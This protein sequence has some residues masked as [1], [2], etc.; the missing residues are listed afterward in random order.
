MTSP[1]P[2]TE[3]FA[4]PNDL[5][6]TAHG[7]QAF[8][9]PSRRGHARLELPVHTAGRPATTQG[10]GSRAALAALALADAEPLVSALEQWLGEALDPVPAWA[11]QPQP[12]SKDS[13]QEACVSASVQGGQLAP[14]ASRLTLPVAW[15]QTAPASA[16]LSEALEWDSVPTRVILDHLRTACAA[17]ALRVGD[18]LLLPGS[19]RAAWAAQ[20]AAVGGAELP[21]AQ[22]PIDTSACL[23][24]G[25]TATTP[26][27]PRLPAPQAWGIEVLLPVHLPLAALLPQ[28]SPSGA[29]LTH[30]PLT[31]LDIG[32]FDA[33][34]ELLAIG[35]LLPIAQ[36][37]GLRVEEVT[38]RSEG[39]VPSEQAAPSLGP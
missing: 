25:D 26:A 24:L 4:G 19:Y 23:R 32:V 33:H 18:V 16:E 21:P 17:D 29:P 22:L 38:A 10:D 5:D 14:E 11:Q 12:A 6:A 3:A 20:A 13:D 9:V 2:L 27:A 30:L 37:W 1:S 8:A 36:G 35:R 7:L 34:G 31:D 28:A 39:E 15:L